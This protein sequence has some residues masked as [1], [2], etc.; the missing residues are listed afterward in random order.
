MQFFNGD[1]KADLSVRWAYIK[2]D[3]FSHVAIQIKTTLL[4][5]YDHC[6]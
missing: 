2:Q 1:A 6:G 4:V 5:L 3:S